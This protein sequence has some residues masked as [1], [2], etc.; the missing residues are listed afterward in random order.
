MAINTSAGVD[1]TRSRSPLQALFKWIRWI[2]LLVIG[3]ASIYFYFAEE[4]HEPSSAQ[5]KQAGQPVTPGLGLIAERRGADVLLSWN[6]EAPAITGATKGV[7]TIR[8]ENSSQQ[9]V[10]S[11]DR[12]RSGSI[13]YLPTGEEIDIGLEVRR[14]GHAV[15]EGVVVIPPLLT[16]DAAWTS[17]SAV[18]AAQSSESTIQGHDKDLSSATNSPELNAES[19]LR[20]RGKGP[21]VMLARDES[22]ASELHGNPSSLERLIRDGHLFTVAAGTAVAA[23]Q[24][25]S[26]QVKVRIMEGISAGQEGWIDISQVSTK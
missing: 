14:V 3:L 13:L 11:A 17:R 23:H 15:A 5:A 10:L 26:R 7:L 1:T 16:Q 12:L 19:K 8:G 2:G 4:Q 18:S 25:E 24:M 22:V 9:I 20:L 21:V 6:H